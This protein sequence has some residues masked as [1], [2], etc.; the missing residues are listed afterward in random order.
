MI[1]KRINLTMTIM[2]LIGGVLGFIIGEILLSLYKYTLP[3]SVLMGL[4]FGILA[5]CIGVMCLIAEMISP[6]LNGYG[7]KNNYLK[8]SFKFLIPCTLVAM[9][10]MGT[11]FQFVYQMNIGKTKKI[12]DVVMLLDTSGS[13]KE[14]DPE[15]ERFK[16]TLNLL[17]SMKEDN[18]ASIYKFNDN[19]EKILP[20]TEITPDTKD[21]VEE[22]LEEHKNPVGKTNMSEALKE[23][24]KE[25]ES[26][27]SNDRS[28]MIILLSDGGDSFNLN[29]EFE[30]TMNPIIER[31]IPVYTIGMS[32]GNDSSML[33]KIARETGGAYHNVENVKEL[34]DVFNKIYNSREQ[35]L[36]VDKRNGVSEEKTL[37]MILRIL[38]VA[39][40]GALIPVCV[41]FVFDNKNLLKGF[42]IGGSISGIVAGLIIE[43]GFLHLP[44]I[45]VMHRFL[46]DIIIAS[47]FTLIPVKVDIKDYSKSSYSRNSKK[48]HIE[49]EKRI[50]NKFD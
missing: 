19:V 2:S 23:A 49:D 33:K 16:A 35:R 32:S 27:S 26:T 24:Y 20:M 8:T 13:M 12:N 37:Y 30:D 48:R 44:W 5:F 47:I 9:F 29:S 6:R 1:E 50:I 10:I 7:W 39:I 18:R 3:N 34:N 17:N 11:I 42:I 36:L 21:Y 38:F 45:G 43:Y 46:A 40:L 14:T 41:S 15:N 28:A 4:Y 31:G 22:K 25:I